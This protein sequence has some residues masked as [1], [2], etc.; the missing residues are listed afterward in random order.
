MPA[1]RDTAGVFS[2]RQALV[3]EPQWGYVI[4]WK[5]KT[6]YQRRG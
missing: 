6:L 4:I 2:M 1:K 5:G 3:I